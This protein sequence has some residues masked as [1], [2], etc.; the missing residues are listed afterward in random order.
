MK[1]RGIKGDRGLELVLDPTRA[2]ASLWRR[3]RFEADGNSREALF[4]RYTTLARSIAARH[5]TWKRRPADRGDAEQ[6]AYEGL[7]QALDRY[8]PLKG[9][10]FTAY[11]RP[12]IAGSVADGLTRQTDMD[13]QFGHRRRLRQERS[14]SV[15]PLDPSASPLDALAD[16][17]VD[18]ALGLMLEGTGMME[19]VDGTD[20]RPDAYEGLAW[21]EAQAALAGGI[22]ALPD[23]EATVIRQHYQT[24]LSFAHIADLLRLT[25]GRISQLHRSAIERLR[26]RLKHH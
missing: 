20:P 10:P 5:L 16:L 9:I 14:R 26:R 21:R 8:D 22:A 25:R 17:A 3:A 13:A 4:N 7:L 19:R 23:A 15:A 24:G 12:R 6:F 1:R 2:E 11:A 18:L